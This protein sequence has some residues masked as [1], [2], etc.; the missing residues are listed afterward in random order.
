M[1]DPVWELYRLAHQLSGGRSTL[2]EWDENIPEFKVV[3][4]E[5]KKAKKYMRKTLGRTSAQAAG[6]SSTPHQS[7]QSA[8]GKAGGRERGASYSPVPSAEAGSSEVGVAS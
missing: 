1:I 2:L 6:T 8:S 7:R 3:H 5:V 4:A